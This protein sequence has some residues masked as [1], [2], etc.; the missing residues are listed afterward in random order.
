MARQAQQVG[1]AISDW[2]RSNSNSIS[3]AFTGESAVMLLIMVVVL[4]IVLIILYIIYVIKTGSNAW[5]DILDSKVVNLAQDVGA[6]SGTKSFAIN[7]NVPSQYSVSAWV[8]LSSSMTPTTANK[9]VYTMSADKPAVTMFMDGTYNQLYVSILTD[10]GVSSVANWD[11]SNYNSFKQPYTPSTSNNQYL[12]FKMDYLPMQRWVNIVITV[13]ETIATMFVDGQIYSV[14][15]VY[16]IG[17]KGV[18]FRKLITN[19]N[20]VNY[21]VG[22]GNNQSGANMYLA[23]LQVYNFAMVQQDVEKSYVT[24]PYATTWLGML[25]LGKYK[26][27]WPVVRVGTSED[28]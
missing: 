13:N 6:I 9:V 15:S 16:D 27:R 28:A 7:Q 21:T 2:F 11:S 18:T 10:G 26:L 25:G 4:C 23:N 12:T 3:N 8:Y 17:G 24:G 19:E 20:R 22:D 5:G 1:G 14:M